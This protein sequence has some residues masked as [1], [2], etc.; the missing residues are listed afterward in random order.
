MGH[1]PRLVRR[2]AFIISL[3]IL[4][5][6]AFVVRCWDVRD[7]FIDGRIFFVDPDCYSRMTRAQLVDEGHGL[8]QR[9][10]DFENYPTG[11]TPHTTAPLD[12]VIVV[13]KR[14]LGLGFQLSQSGRQSVLHEQMLDV[15]GAV[16]SPLLGALLCGW[17]VCAFA[18]MKNVPRSAAWAVGI[19]A[20]VSPIVVHGTLLGR[21][22]HQS[23]L[24][25]LL[26]VALVAE[27]QLCAEFTRRWGLVAGIAWAVAC[28]V[29]FYEPLIVLAV[30]LVFWLCVDRARFSSQECRAGW[31]AFGTILVLTTLLEGWR[32]ALPDA[33]MRAYFVRWT[34]RIGELHHMSF[35][36]VLSWLGWLFVLVPVAM[37]WILIREFRARS[38]V[39]ATG[40]RFARPVG[41]LLTLLLVLASLAAWQLR[42]GYFLALA[43]ALTLPWVFLVLRRVWIAWPVFIIALWPVADDWDRHLFPDD[44]T[45][46]KLAIQRR[47]VSELRDVAEH[48]RGPE[49]AGFL[50][51][52]WISPQLAYWSG[53]PGVAGSSH[54]SLAGIVD[55]AR[56]FFATTP[57]EAAEILRRRD[58][59]AVVTDIP[60]NVLPVSAQ[61]LGREESGE[62]L[63]AVLGADE[64]KAPP[65]LVEPPENRT[66]ISVAPFYRFYRVDASQFPEPAKDGK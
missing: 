56:F 17:L 15:A 46:E 28:W 5:A 29:S 35:A 37:G 14:T 2:F 51:P 33:A 11:V 26:G 41:L 30:V 34:S 45:L 13:L 64:P 16:V 39:N 1:F 58:V 31:I 55:A 47:E 61:I 63:G 66:R 6:S 23:L 62:V 53:Q 32:I 52:W 27:L 42:W 65:F 20:A 7:I 48:M 12:W 49:R 10:H 3:L 43:F 25:V 24:L 18:R 22:D 40:T 38:S 44:E 50:A 9:H 8:F 57:A 4:C 21:P 54:E 59:R 60:A 36:N 19:F